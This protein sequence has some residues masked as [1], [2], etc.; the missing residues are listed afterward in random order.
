[1]DQVI[2]IA[3]RRVLDCAPI[4]VVQTE[5][6]GRDLVGAALGQRCDW[7]LVPVA[8]LAPDF[9]RLGTGLA[10]EIVQKFANYAIGLAVIGDIEAHLAKSG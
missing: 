5:Q 2:D 3:G 10:G 6:Q 8:R 9:F 7:A 4:P 1:M